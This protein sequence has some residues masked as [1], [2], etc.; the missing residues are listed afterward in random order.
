MKLIKRRKK[1]IESFLTNTKNYLINKFQKEGFLNTKVY[2]NTRKDTLGDNTL[3]LL[4]NIDRGVRVKVKSI[5]FI[6]NNE[7]KSSKIRKK[8]KNTKIKNP[9][10]FWKKSKFIESDYLE[11]LEKVVDYFKEKGFR[12]ARIIS[13]TIINTNKK[14]LEIEIKLEEGNK[15]IFGDLKFIGNSAFNSTQLKTVLGINKGDIY[16]GVLLKKRIADQT[17]PDGQDIT[18]LYQNNGYLFSNINAVEVSA[19]NDTIDFEIRINEGN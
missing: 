9:V 3:K 1:I 11:D 14:N 4:I 8:L 15:Y 5:K 6:G 2:L 18:N 12:D 13:D 10:R 19:K 7:V 17:K 16:N